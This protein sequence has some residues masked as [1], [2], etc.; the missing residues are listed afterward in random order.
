MGGLRDARNLFAH[1]RLKSLFSSLC[2]NVFGPESVGMFSFLLIISGPNVF[3]FC[4][5]QPIIFLMV[6][7]IPK[8]ELNDLILAAPDGS[9]IYFSLIRAAI[10]ISLTYDQATGFLSLTE[11][12]L[13]LPDSA[14][15]F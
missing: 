9:D 5:T 13:G 14:N 7:P 4:P 6:H 10:S 11:T 8:P 1:V 15:A 2:I 12:Y 3:C